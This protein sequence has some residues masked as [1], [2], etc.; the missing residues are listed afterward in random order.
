MSNIFGILCF[1]IK[2]KVKTQLKQKKICTVYGESA[3]T[4]WT[5]QKWF[6]KFLAGNFSLDDAPRSVRPVEVD[7]NQIKTLT[8]NNQRYAIQET[9]NIF[10]ISKS[11]KLLGKMKNVS[12]F[13]GKTKQ[14]FLPIQ[15]K[16]TSIYHVQ[17]TIC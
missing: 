12:Y 2:R 5:H 6:A 17:N 9:A 10:K 1:I 15:Y 4:D 7:G 3:V 11:I 16:S 13:T 14:I 8:E